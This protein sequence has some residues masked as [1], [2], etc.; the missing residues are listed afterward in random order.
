MFRHTDRATPKD[1]KKDAGNQSKT[2]SGYKHDGQL[3]CMDHKRPMLFDGFERP[4]LGDLRPGQGAHGHPGSVAFRRGLARRANNFRVRAI[5]DH[6]AGPAQRVSLKAAT[7]WRRLNAYPR[8]PDGKPELYAERQALGMRLKN[9]ME[10]HFNRMQSSM[11]LLTED[12]DRVRL[13]HW[14]KVETLLHLAE[15]RMNALSLAAERGHCGVPQTLPVDGEPAP[16]P[17]HPYGRAGRLAQ[18]RT[19]ATSATATATATARVSRGQPAPAPVRHVVPS[20]LSA[21]AASAVTAVRPDAD[22]G[23][24]VAAVPAA[25]AAPATPAARAA[26]P[27]LVAVASSPPEDTNVIAVDFTARRRKR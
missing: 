10:G 6:G 26:A 13:Q 23:E 20:A 1:G 24:V 11:S 2:V 4:A 17:A 7:D 18:C 8:F 25:P 22:G 27:T 5:H 15:L 3:L 14:D 9:Q 19:T 16:L 12:A 21:P